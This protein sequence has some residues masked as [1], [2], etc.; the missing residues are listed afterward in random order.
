VN[1]AR[2]LQEPHPRPTEGCLIAWRE[3]LGF[4]DVRDCQLTIPAASELPQ[5]YLELDNAL[6]TEE[7]EQ[8]SQGPIRA[9]PLKP[10]LNGYNLPPPVEP[11]LVLLLCL[12]SG[13]VAQGD[14][15]SLIEAILLSGKVSDM[16]RCLR[17]SDAQTFIDVVDEVHYPSPPS[18]N[19]PLTLFSPLYILIGVGELRSCAK[20][21]K[22]MSEVVVQNMRSP[23]PASQI[24]ADRVT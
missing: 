13:A 14:R 10:T 17:G 6:A 5:G 15:A 1:C 3:I 2:S 9:K 11:S 23:R 16:V 21:P 18:R 20:G 12:T 7:N 4:F 22:E 24:T 19:G 8:H